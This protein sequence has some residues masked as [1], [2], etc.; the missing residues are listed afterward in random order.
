MQWTLLQ[1]WKLNNLCEHISP[2]PILLKTLSKASP[3]WLKKVH[4]LGMTHK[5]LCDPVP[6]LAFALLYLCPSGTK[7]LVF[8]PRWCCFLRPRDSVSPVLQSLPGSY[9]F[10]STL[11]SSRK[12]SLVSPGWTSCPSQCFPLYL[13]V[14]RLTILSWLLFYYCF[15]DLFFH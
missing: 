9:S 13:P 8:P 5:G 3:N 15:R 12:P 2:C 7:L 14:T 10:I 4:T 6:A 1:C 11:A